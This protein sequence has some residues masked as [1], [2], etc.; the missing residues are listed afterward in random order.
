MKHNRC[1]APTCGFCGNRSSCG[2]NWSR[3][4]AQPAASAC[5]LVHLLERTLYHKIIPKMVIN[6]YMNEGSEAGTHSPDASEYLG[7]NQLM[8]SLAA[9]Q[10]TFIAQKPSLRATL[11]WMK[12]MPQWSEHSFWEMIAQRHLALWILS[13]PHL[14]RKARVH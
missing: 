12:L 7:W 13:A 10:I 14:L 2:R 8:E 9:N 6:L 1:V 3:C 11:W 5:L 4:Q